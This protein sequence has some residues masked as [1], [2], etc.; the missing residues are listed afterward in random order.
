MYGGP[1]DAKAYTSKLKFFILSGR[2]I[3]KG[4]WSEQ[5]VSTENWSKWWCVRNWSKWKCV[6][7][8]SKSKCVNY[9]QTC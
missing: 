4:N 7:N 6:R 1:S 5:E 3:G 8:W 2:V 9:I